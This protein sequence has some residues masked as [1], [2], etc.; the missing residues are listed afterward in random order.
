[1]EADGAKAIDVVMKELKLFLKIDILYVIQNFFTNNFPVY[2]KDA[3]DKP[4][5]FESDFGNYPRQAIIVNLNDCL[6]CFE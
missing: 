5:Y 3:K 6:I 1:M 2:S 4:T